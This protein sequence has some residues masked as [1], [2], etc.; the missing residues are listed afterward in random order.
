MSDYEY[1][2]YDESEADGE[3][4]EGECDHCSGGDEDAVTA[5][6][7]LGALYCACRIGQGADEEDCHCGPI[8]DDQVGQ[9]CT[10]CS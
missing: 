2:D 6:G 9:P 1:D 3:W 4:Q 7:P 8:D 10:R 5:T